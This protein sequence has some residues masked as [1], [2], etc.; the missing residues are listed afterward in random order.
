MCYFIGA[1]REEF[2][3]KY[4]LTAKRL[5]EAMA[6]KGLRQQDLADV[7][8]ISKGNISHYVNGNH[9]PNNIM[10]LKLAKALDVK[11][12]WIMGI[13]EAA[14]Y[15]LIEKTP[16][17]DAIQSLTD[18]QKQRVYEYVKEMMKDA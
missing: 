12:D 6:R 14:E 4:E 18:E 17:I 7:T 10:A 9:V 11:P 1:R 15:A 5:R 8:G 3:M 2:I 16:L 13:D